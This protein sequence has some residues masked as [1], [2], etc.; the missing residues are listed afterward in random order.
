MKEKLKEKKIE[1]KG[2]IWY[3][4]IILRREWNDRINE[5]DVYKVKAYGFEKWI[6]SSDCKAQKYLRNNTWFNSYYIIAFLIKEWLLFFLLFASMWK[7]D[8]RH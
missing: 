1:K 6:C 2:M 8:E 7:R 5:M 4:S 3:G